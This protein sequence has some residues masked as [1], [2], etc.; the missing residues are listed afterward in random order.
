V[1]LAVL[2]QAHPTRAHLAECLLDCLGTGEIV[3]D[4]DPGHTPSPWRTYEACL[5]RGLELGDDHILVIQEDVLICGN[6]LAGVARALSARPDNPVAFFVPGKPPAYINA[7]YR[8]RRDGGAFAEL[9]LG[10][11]C[12]VVAT[13]WPRHLAEGLLEWSVPNRPRAWAADDEIAG[14]FLYAVSVPVL[15][16]VPSLVEHPDTEPSVMSRHR[17]VGDGRDPGRRAY[18]YIGDEPETFGCDA[19]RIE[20]DS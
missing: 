12:P 19:A 18:Y 1:S 14:R 7:I 8:V 15:A 10:T 3:Y 20:W 6:F 13:A 5:R 17:R 9:P 2:I 11:W 4:P 16:S